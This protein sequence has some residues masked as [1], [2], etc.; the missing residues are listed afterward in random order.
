MS[1]GSAAVRGAA[2]LVLA[3]LAACG[4]EPARDEAHHEAPAAIVARRDEG[5]RSDWLTPDDRTD[6]ARWLAARTTGRT[7]PPGDAAGASLQAALQEALQEALARARSHF[8]EDPRMIA[9]RT[10]QVAG[11]MPN[12]PAPDTLI[13]GLTAVAA[14]TGRR[15]LYGSL[16]Q[17]YVTLRAGGADHD[18]A[19]DR[20][21]ESYAAQS[22]N[23]PTAR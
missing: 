1:L 22:P 6:P 2:S 3:V 16:C 5:A 15:Q 18:A 23:A 21:R 17:Q 9:N 10:A 12:A 14:S 19:L 8:I 4:D 7:L 20:L 13:A 11:M